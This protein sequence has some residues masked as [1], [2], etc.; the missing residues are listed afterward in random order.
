MYI[1]VFIT[2]FLK[3]SLK[4]IKYRKF[5]R[6]LYKVFEMSIPNRL[7]CK[8]CASFISNKPE[9]YEIEVVTFEDDYG[10]NVILES[11]KVYYF[12]CKTCNALVKDVEYDY[13]R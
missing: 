9:K 5:L 3:Y 10:Y 13:N 4:S 1:L 12:F 7:K 11:R 6:C 8:K 2:Y